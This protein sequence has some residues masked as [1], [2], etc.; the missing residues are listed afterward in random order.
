MAPAV[1]N[2][3]NE[4]AVQAFLEGRLRYT[5]IAQVIADTLDRVAC[6]AAEELGAI[7]EADA[8]ARRAA[9]D[10]VARLMGQA[11]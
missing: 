11:A 3:A 7:L 1:L 8:R 5:A 10:C 6:G 2:A 4:V 9:A